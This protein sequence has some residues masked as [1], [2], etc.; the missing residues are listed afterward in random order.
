MGASVGEADSRTELL[1]EIYYRA[2]AAGEAATLS[3]AQIAEVA[4]KQGLRITLEP[5]PEAGW[6]FRSDHFPFA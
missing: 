2:R 1:E 4:A 5:N 3:P 6:Y